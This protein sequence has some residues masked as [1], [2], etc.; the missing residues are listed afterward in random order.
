MTSM[1]HSAQDPRHPAC[2][3][4]ANNRAIARHGFYLRY[5]PGSPR[6]QAI[7]RFRCL[8]RECRHRTFS[9]LPPPFL[10]RMRHSLAFLLVLDRLR[11]P[12]YSLRRLCRALHLA[13]TTVRRA[14]HQAGRLT[15]LASTLPG[16]SP[17]PL[18][19]QALWLALTRNARKS[20]HSGAEHTR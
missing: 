5:R 12:E 11:S 10:P 9:I 3:H 2:P 13:R 1:N 17:L 4:C 6:Q 18:Q 7:P 14:R 20:P 8:N 19:S 15:A 16:P